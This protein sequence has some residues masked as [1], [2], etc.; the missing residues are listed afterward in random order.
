M[1]SS[2]NHRSTR[3][4]HEAVRRRE[5]D[6]EPR[7]FGEPVP[8]QCRFVGAVVVH[9]DVHGESSRH[10]GINEIKK[11]AKL[12]RSMSLMKLRDD[13][14]GLGIERGE[15]RRRPMPFVVVRAAFDL[16]GLHRQQRLRAIE[17][18]NLRF[19][20]DAEH[21]R[22]GRRIQ[23]QAHDVADL[24]DQQ[25]VVRQFERLAA[26]RLQAE[27]VP[28]PADRHVT[29]TD[30]L[31]HVA[32]APVGGAARRRFERADDH[33]FHLLVR[34][35]SLR[36]GSRLIVEPV[37]AM[38]NKP[39]SPFR[40]SP[41]CEMQSPRDHLAVGSVSTRQDDPRTTRDLRRRARPMRQRLQ[42]LPFVCRQNQPNLGSS[43]SHAR[44]LVEQYERP[45]PF[46]SVSTVTGH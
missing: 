38:R 26:M 4:S 23:I 43:R 34:D 1:V 42:S 20:I 40:H 37:Q 32:R 10:L 25:R 7:S 45:A 17:R 19:L 18:L 46:V 21:R 29:Q 16:A 33:L 8:N 13:L 15:Q 30:D 5:M 39:A 9:D 31:R 22:M 6:M 24:L 44:L 2:A 3:L 28:N 11:F 27:G 14:A 12:C 36:A 35:R 41:R